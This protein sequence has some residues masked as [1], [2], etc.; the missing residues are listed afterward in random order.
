MKKYRKQILAGITETQP[1][2]IPITI[3]ST[4]SA[5]SQ[6][7]DI[8]ALLEVEAKIVS[9]GET[10]TRLI[11]NQEN[12][13]TEEEMNNLIAAMNGEAGDLLLFAA[14]KNK[15]YGMSLEIYVWNWQN[16]WNF[17]TRISTISCGSQ[18]SRCLSGVMSRTAI[19]Q[20]TIHL[21]CRWKKICSTLIP[22][23]EESVQKR[24]ISS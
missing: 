23:R 8:N 21:P 2:L 5:V 13:M 3:E 15:L 17:W 4:M 9:T 12:S 14:D 7:N 6:V 20:C 19:W 18:N 24:T 1:L 22:I 16:R 10:I 11:K